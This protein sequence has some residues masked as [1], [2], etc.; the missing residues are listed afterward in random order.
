VKVVNDSK[1][2]H[3]SLI[4]N[5]HRSLTGAALKQF[6]LDLRQQLPSM[7]GSW[8]PDHVDRVGSRFTIKCRIGPRQNQCSQFLD[9]DLNYPEK[10][11]V[12]NSK[13]TIV[14]LWGGA[15]HRQEKLAR[16]SSVSVPV[17]PCVRLAERYRHRLAIYKPQ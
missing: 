12:K 1:K 9:H 11:V 4:V 17:S 7:P 3:G 2:W 15:R 14:N 6:K 8:G 13:K 5:P 16:R 10:H